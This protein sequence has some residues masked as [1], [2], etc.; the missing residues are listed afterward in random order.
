MSTLNPQAL[1]GGPEPEAEHSTPPA[2]ATVDAEWQGTMSAL[3]RTEAL[4]DVVFVVN[5]ERLPALRHLCAAHSEPLA[6]M[7][8][9]DWRSHVHSGDIDV[10]TVVVLGDTSAGAAVLVAIAFVVGSAVLLPDR[11]SLP[12]LDPL[13]RACANLILDLFAAH[14]VGVSF[15]SRHV[16]SLALFQC[17]RFCGFVQFW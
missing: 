16:A 14:V 7:F 12:D 5:G 11:D 17:N 3:I 4:C 10:D 1:E 8:G 15:S 13:F 2:N 9:E 6:M